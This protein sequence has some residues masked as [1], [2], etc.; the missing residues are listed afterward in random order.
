MPEKRAGAKPGGWAGAGAVT[1][2]TGAGA[3]TAG[4]A[5]DGGAATG[6]SAGGGGGAISAR[7]GTFFFGASPQP[8]TNN[9]TV[10]ATQS[11]PAYNRISFMTCIF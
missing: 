6:C 8:F 11:L 2:A 1:G 5:D 3:G 4:G 7:D 9:S 10:A